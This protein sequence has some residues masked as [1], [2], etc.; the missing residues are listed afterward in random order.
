MKTIT[1]MGIDWFMKLNPSIKITQEQIA[2]CHYL[3]R[4]GQQ[5]CVDFGYENAPEKVWAMMDSEIAG[6]EMPL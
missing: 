2:C 6:M 3:E 5:F 4:E 1:K